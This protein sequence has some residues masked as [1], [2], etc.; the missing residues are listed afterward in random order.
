M[1]QLEAL[2]DSRRRGGKALRRGG[3]W[4]EPG[5][6]RAAFALVHPKVRFIEVPEGEL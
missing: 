5:M 3:L 4:R 6:A 2:G 1:L